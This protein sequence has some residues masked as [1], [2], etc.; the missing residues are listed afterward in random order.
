LVAGKEGEIGVQGEENL[1]P[2]LKIEVEG[3]V[4]KI[5]TEKGKNLQPSKNM[6]V[7][8]NVSSM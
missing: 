4:L 1:L 6:K 7:I 8:I 3:N 5:Y 2:F